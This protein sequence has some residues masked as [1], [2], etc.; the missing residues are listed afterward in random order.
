MQ[1]QRPDCHTICSRQV[2]ATSQ[3]SY[4][5]H[6]GTIPWLRGQ[7]WLGE[8]VVRCAWQNGETDL[9]LQASICQP[10]CHLVRGSNRAAREGG[11]HGLRGDVTSLIALS[12]APS[13]CCGRVSCSS[14][15][16]HTLSQCLVL[17]TLWS[18]LPPSPTRLHHRSSIT[19][20]TADTTT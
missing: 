20:S 3:L 4:L 6:P 15:Y 2:T 14:R 9:A 16:L 10:G 7:W 19:L 18:L 17:E 12:P 11:R 13:Y 8:G 1:H 5:S